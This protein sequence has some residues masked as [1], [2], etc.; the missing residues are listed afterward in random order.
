M[1][2]LGAIFSLSVNLSGRKVGSSLVLPKCENFLPSSDSFTN[3]K[4]GSPA[5]AGIRKLLISPA[6]SK[7]C[8][9]LL[10][11][12]SLTNDD[13]LATGLVSATDL[14]DFPTDATDLPVLDGAFLS[15]ALVDD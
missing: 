7:A 2:T 1:H 3:L 5:K 8:N 15:P 11:M 6:A 9:L 14:S 12:D 10:G 4:Q 13:L